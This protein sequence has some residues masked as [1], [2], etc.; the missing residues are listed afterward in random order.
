MFHCTDA[1]FHFSD[2]GKNNAKLAGWSTDRANCFFLH[3]DFDYVCQ[4]THK[5][6]FL[7]IGMYVRNLIT[8]LTLLIH[9]ESY[10]FL[11]MKWYS[12]LNRVSFL[13]FLLFSSKHANRGITEVFLN[14]SL[15]T[16]CIF[17]KSSS[18]LQ[19]ERSS[20]YYKRLTIM[21]DEQR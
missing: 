19:M 10:K 5:F 6:Y 1:F 2:F 12:V 8:F 21:Y 3:L 7:G 4:R 18:F 17:S 9:D 16:S 13:L 11:R 15:Q 14:P 20:S